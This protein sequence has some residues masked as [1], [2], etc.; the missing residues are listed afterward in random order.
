MKEKKV[1]P[2][3]DRMIPGG[4][5]PIVKITSPAVGSFE[6]LHYSVDCP[7]VCHRICLIVKAKF[8]PKMLPSN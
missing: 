4:A 2:I 3:S 8:T 1:S 7:T 6:A 5:L